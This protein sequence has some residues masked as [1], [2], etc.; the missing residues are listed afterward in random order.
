[1]KNRLKKDFLLY[2]R[3]KRLTKSLFLA[4]SKIDLKEDL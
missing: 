1:M 4:T 2:L 3:I